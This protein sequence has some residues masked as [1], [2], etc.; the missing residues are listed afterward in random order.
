[1]GR[2]MLPM[3]TLIGLF[4]KAGCSDV[5][6]YIQ[7]GNVVFSASPDLAKRMSVVIEKEIERRFR[8]SVPVVIRSSEDIHAVVNGNPFLKAGVDPARL[9]VVFL[10]DAP[11]AKQAEILDPNRSPGDSFEVR[12]GEIFLSLTSAAK[13]KITNAWLDSKLKTVST[14]RNWRTVLK[15]HD[16]LS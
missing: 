12:G 10:A 15:L 1:G 5:K 6:T 7:S 3:K 9:H 16:L 13:T 4:E 8:I 14:A 2:N 11:T